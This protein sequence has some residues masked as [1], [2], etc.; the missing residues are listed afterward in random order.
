MITFRFRV[1]DD[2]REDNGQLE[3]WELKVKIR[4]A[5]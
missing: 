4:Q 3:G 5:L 2:S 1:R